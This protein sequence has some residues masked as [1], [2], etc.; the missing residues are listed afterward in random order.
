[1]KILSLLS[2][3]VIVASIL[4][5]KDRNEIL[6]LQR[7]NQDLAIQLNK[8]DSLSSV[9]S[10]TLKDIEAILDSISPENNTL[11]PIPVEKKLVTVLTNREN[12]IKELLFAK[13]KKYNALKSS[14][15]KSDSSISEMSEKI[16]NLDSEIREK[17]S[18]NFS[19]NQTV[20]KYKIQ[21]AQQSSQ[22]DSVIQE[23]QKLNEILETKTNMLNSAYYI[24][25]REK[26]LK[27]KA[28]IEK[29]G[30]FL[31]LLGRVNTLNPNLDTNHLQM[32]DITEQTVFTLDTKKKRIQFITKHHPS[33]FELDESSSETSI[34]TITKPAEFWRNSK[35]LVITY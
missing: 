17:E 23:K 5:C 9:Y 20:D 34:L 16:E 31:G 14:L 6:E 10:S 18:I 30:G 25:G 13:E 7:Q 11:D 32:I 12:E 33:S 19:L 35:Y 1:M 29:T 24:V 2:L 15:A 4:G 22:I 8:S 26:E 27:N 21:I 3:L 28:I